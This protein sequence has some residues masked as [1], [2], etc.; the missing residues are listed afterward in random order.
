MTRKKSI[1]KFTSFETALSIIEGQSLFFSGPNSFNDPLDCVIDRLTF[2][3]KDIGSEAEK[4]LKDLENRFG[5]TMD[6]FT[7][8]RLEILFKKSVQNKLDRTSVCCF[9]NNKNNPL[10]WAHYGEKNTGICLEF[11]FDDQSPFEE[12][13]SDQL[14]WGDINYNE[15]EPFNYLKDKKEGIWILYKNKS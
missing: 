13:Q 9:S 14:T 15:P 10:M 1:F 7:P 2:D 6:R 11:E 8:E 4:D 3:I 5:P 12:I